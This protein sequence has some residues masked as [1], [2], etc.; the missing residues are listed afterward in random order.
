MDQGIILNKGD[1]LQISGEK[2]RVKGLA[3]RI[4]FISIHSQMSDLLAFCCFFILGLGLGMITLTFGQ[5][6]FG[7]GNAA[8]LLLAGIS[9]AFYAPTTLPSAMC[10]KG[11]LIWSKI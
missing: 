4:G 11:R 3:D 2:S 1:V 5:V 6:T 9:L 8:G 10:H 7:L